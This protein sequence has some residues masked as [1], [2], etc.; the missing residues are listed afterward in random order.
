[1]KFS[2]TLQGQDSNW[3]VRPS[4]III[5]NAVQIKEYQEKKFNSDVCVS[6]ATPAAAF[7]WKIDKT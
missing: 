5:I 7:R 1:M 4:I 6:I 2:N 3:I